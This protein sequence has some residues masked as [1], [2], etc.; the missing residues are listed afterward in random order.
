MVF[1]GY[2]EFYCQSGGSNTNAGSTNNNT[3]IKT[4]TH[5]NWTQSTGVFT[6]TDGTNPSGSISVGDWV[7]VMVDGATVAASISRVSAVQNANNGTITANTTVIGSKPANQTGTATLVDGGAWQGPNGASG[8]PFTLANWTTN[9]DASNH[10]AR[11]NMKNDQT[12]SITSGISVVVG[13]NTYIMEGYSGS[14]GDGGRATIDGGT[15][16]GTL[17]SECG[18]TNS[19]IRNIIFSTSITSGSTTLVTAGHSITYVNCV[20]KGSRV[21]GLNAG[22]GNCSLI[23]CEAYGNN[24]SGTSGGAGVFAGAGTNIFRCFIHDNTGSNS[25]GLRISSGPATVRN[26]VI[27]G[28]SLYGLSSEGNAANNAIAITECDFYNNGSDAIN[29]ATGNMNQ[30]WIENCNF[31]KNTGAAIN[32]VSVLNGGYVYNCG[33]GAGTQA[34]GSA[35]TLNGLSTSGAVTYASNVTPWVDPVNYNFNINLAA[36]EGT[37][38]GAFTQ[39]YPT[40]T[41]TPGYP[42]VGYPDIGA[43]Q[44]QIGTAFPTPTAT[45]TVTPTST[46]TPT[47]TATVTPTVTPTP[48]APIETSYTFPN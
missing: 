31:I 13:A 38:R 20:F 26:C 11:V 25:Y 32:N 15:S 17:L 12:Y 35:D 9:R 48:T 46:P 42:T 30:H 40:P 7:A 28:N 18:P 44:A 2:T 41:P 37:G 34:N 3:P 8:F 19:E 47:A 24:T 6:V 14:I 5:G 23:E 16:T 21:H 33:Y 45:P 29:I 1:A 43:A 39:L 22:S 10:F 36:A 4:Y 27:S